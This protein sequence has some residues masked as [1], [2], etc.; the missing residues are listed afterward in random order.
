MHYEWWRPEF[1]ALMRAVLVPSLGKTW[2]Q[3]WKEADWDYRNLG[4]FF[5]WKSVDNFNRPSGAGLLPAD[6]VF[7]TIEKGGRAGYQVSVGPGRGLV[8]VPFGDVVRIVKP[9]AAA[10]SGGRP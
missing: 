9:F 1:D 10:P 3:V 7:L 8:S 2:E 6:K 4:Q 5:L